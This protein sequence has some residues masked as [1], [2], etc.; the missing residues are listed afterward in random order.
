MSSYMPTWKFAV[1]LNHSLVGLLGI[2]IVKTYVAYLRPFPCVVVRNTFQVTWGDP[3]TEVD[4]TLLRACIFKMSKD[5]DDFTICPTHRSNLV[6]SVGWSCGSISSCRVPKV[7]GRGKG[8]VK[9]I[10]KADWEIGKCVP[11]IVHTMSRKFIL[12]PCAKLRIPREVRSRL[13]IGQYPPCQHLTTH[14]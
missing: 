9:L 12:P 13:G 5:M 14:F 10:P 3:E 4:L 11:Q 7:Y 6:T 1:H 2:V 8:R